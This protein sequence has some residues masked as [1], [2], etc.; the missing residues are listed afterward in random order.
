MH[1]LVLAGAVK[2]AGDTD[3][4]RI[5]GQQGL[6]GQMTAA[7][8]IRFYASRCCYASMGLQRTRP[9]RPSSRAFF[10]AANQ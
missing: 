6:L 2:S 5:L 7:I 8:C 3:M 10:S 1:Q 4:H 9:A